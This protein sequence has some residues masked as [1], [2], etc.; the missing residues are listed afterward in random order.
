[1]RLRKSWPGSLEPPEDEDRRGVTR[2]LRFGEDRVKPDASTRSRAWAGK[3]PASPP[4]L[5][6]APGDG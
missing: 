5:A 6:I 4:G 1:M 2:L 3:C